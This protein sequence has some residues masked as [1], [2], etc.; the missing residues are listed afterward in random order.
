MIDSTTERLQV[1]DI[2]NPVA[3]QVD[4]LKDVAEVALDMINWWESRN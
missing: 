4:A 2:G 3:E 1:L